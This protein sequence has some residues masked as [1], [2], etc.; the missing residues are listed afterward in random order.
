METP[1][2]AA[3]SLRS[4]FDAQRSGFAATPLPNART[5][6]EWLS[7]LAALLKDNQQAISDAIAADFGCRS[8]AETRLLEFYPSL[9]AVAYARRHVAEW[10][11][12]ERRRTSL[13]FVPGRSEVRYQPLGVVGIIAPWNYPLYLAVGPLAGALA[14]GNRVMVKLSEYSQEFGALLA[15]LVRERFPED[16]LTVVTGD[17]AVAAEFASLPFDHLLFTGSTTVGRLVMAAAAK[18]LTPVTLELG[19]KCPVVIAPGQ[20]MDYAASRIVFAKLANAGQTCVAPDYVLVPR[21]EEGDL[22]EAARA[23]AERFYTNA[24]S[25]DYTSIGHERHY[26]RLRHLLDDTRAQGAR[27]EPLMASAKDGTRKMTPAAV[28]DVRDS[29]A[30]MR[31]EIFG[32]ILPI[33]SYDG[34]DSA[35]A[36]INARPRP[37]ALYLF[38]RNRRRIEQTLA[39]TASGG[40][41]INDCLMHIGQDDL[42]F[43]G[44]GASGMGRYHGPEGFKTFSQIRPVFHQSRLGILPLLYPPFTRAITRTLLRLMQ[45]VKKGSGTSLRP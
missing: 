3:P 9:E 14:A 13:L 34:I 8:D 41:T 36:Y 2:S 6:R 10:M 5:R 11:R 7:A 12:P 21:G 19:G 18:Q 4:R 44:V 17:A 40:V 45:F 31:E 1:N 30:I 24:D 23:A 39:Q 37:L 42:P 33:V 35:I 15:R 26:W 32:P 28:L 16:L 29:M 22:I 27:I 43:G 25:P 20:D 38:D